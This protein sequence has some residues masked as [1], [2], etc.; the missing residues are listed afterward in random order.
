MKKLLLFVFVSIVYA[1]LPSQNLLSSDWKFS[2]G[3]DMSWTRSDFDDSHWANARIGEAWEKWGFAK[4]DGFGWYRKTVVIPSKFKKEAERKGGLL[5]NLG[6]IDD[7]DFTYFNGSLV[8]Q[9]GEIPP[10][11]VTKYDADR[12]YIIPLN[13]ILWDQPNIIAVRVYDEAGNGGIIG[14]DISLSVRGAVEMFRIIPMFHTKNRVA[15]GV[16]SVDMPLEVQNMSTTPIVG[17]L[18]YYVLSDFFDTIAVKEIPIKVLP[19]TKH[20]FSSKLEHPTPGVYLVMAVVTS[21]QVNKKIKFNFIYEPEKMRSKDDTPSDMKEFWNRAHKEL[22]AVDPQYKMTKVDSL[23]STSRDCYLVEMRSLGNVLIR[24][25][26]LKPKKTGKFPTVLTVQGYATN[27][28]PEWLFQDDNVISFGLNI[29]GHGNSKDNVNPGF[30]GFL[31]YQLGDKEQFIYRG[32]YMDCVRAVDF[33]CSLPEVDTTKI[34]VEGGS[35]GGALSF[36]TAALCGNRIKVAVPSVPFM[37]DFKEYVKV[38]PWPGNEWLGYGKDHPLYGEVGVL[39]TLS[40]FDIKNLAPWISAKVLMGVGLIDVTCPPRI[41]F[42]AY[43]KLNVEKQYIV[44]PDAGHQ[45]PVDFNGNKQQFIR[46]KLGI[47]THK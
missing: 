42:A 29:R 39:N 43:N 35:Q 5:L 25:W 15:T 11:F 16:S 14:E 4:Y 17:T 31:S 7:V 8:G 12:N 28:I 23:S 24:G 2:I 22:A 36:A 21:E 9:E 3:D 19:K 34:A 30:P 37:S 18:K 33:L 27:V 45:L 32:A 47:A 10:H 46:E 41:N 6:K 38:A 1:Q 44:F 20:I 13:L 26:L 40:Y